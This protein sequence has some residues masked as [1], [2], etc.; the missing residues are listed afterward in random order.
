MSERSYRVWLLG[1]G[2]VAA[3]PL[4][5]CGFPYPAHDAVLHVGWSHQ[6]SAEFWAGC[7]YPR[8]LAGISHGF[9]SPTFFYYPPMPYW[10]SSLFTPLAAVFGGQGADWR[11]LGWASAVG[12]ILSGQTA[13][14]CFRNLTSPERALA[15]ALAYMIAPYHLAIDLLQRA[16]YPE[17]WAFAWMPLALGG[18]IG[19]AKNRRWSWETT[20]CGLALLYLTH[21]PTTLTFMPFVLLFALSQGARS[22]VKA[23]T[24]IAA[25]C[26]VAAVFLLSALTMEWAVNLR[27]HPFPYKLTFFFPNMDIRAPLYSMDGFNERLLWIFLLLAAIWLLCLVTGLARGVRFKVPVRRGVSPHFFRSEGREVA[28][29]GAGLTPAPL[30]WKTGRD[31]MVW[32]GLGLVALVMMLPVS[33]FVYKLIPVFQWIQ[34]SWRFLAPATLVFCVLILVFWPG[35]DSSAVGWVAHATALN[36]MAVMGLYMAAIQ[37][38][39]TCLALPAM[40]AAR[41]LPAAANRDDVFEYRPRQADLA[42]ARQRMGDS[43]AKVVEGKAEVAVLEWR[44]RLIRLRVRSAAPARIVL[45]QFFYPGWSVRTAD[46]H[47]ISVRPEAKTGLVLFEAP[48]GRQVL[49]VRLAA[50]LAERTGWALTLLS[51]AGCVVKWAVC[52]RR[53]AR[54]DLQWPAGEPAPGEAT[55]GLAPCAPGAAERNEKE[56][57]L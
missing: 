41:Q 4:I 51:L 26:G 12:V 35:M 21:L 8:W 52:R 31:R 37:Y 6:F 47:A 24:A 57:S 49:T 48:P 54:R 11:A 55:T 40:E 43:R 28:E 23:C 3:L 14:F 33:N 44:S 36:A 17:F 13:F 56:R 42:A 20:V 34:F 50:G 5:L 25:A 9:G 16:A 39:R 2:A 10:A 45:R 53:R 46:G 29:K 15:A 1:F 27:R 32:L 7:L 19:L 30:R 38:S 18:L 22:F